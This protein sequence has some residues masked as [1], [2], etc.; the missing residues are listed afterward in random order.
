MEHGN[1]TTK[2]H[3]FYPASIHTLVGLCWS[4]TSHIIHSQ[5]HAG[6]TLSPASTHTLAGPCITLH[7]SHTRRP[8]L[9][10][11]FSLHPHT[12]PGPCITLHTSQ[13]RRP[14]LESHFPLHPLTHSQAHASH[15]AHHTLAGPCW[16]P[17]FPASTHTI[18]GSCWNHTSHITHSQAHAEVHSKITMSNS[19]S[20]RIHKVTLS[21]S[22]SL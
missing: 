16:S 1:Q 8:M 4:H 5:A 11:H 12:L 18:A 9:E 3:P 6:V 22:K 21:H 19:N 13:T 17:L 7:T 10:S 2:F 15:F 14:M 20:P